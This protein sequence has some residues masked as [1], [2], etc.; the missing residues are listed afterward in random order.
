MK[1][2]SEKAKEFLEHFADEV[3]QEVQRKLGRIALLIKQDFSD[4]VSGNKEAYSD[5]R[6]EPVFGKS[7]SGYIPFQNGGFTVSKFFLNDED[8][9]YHFTE[10]QTEYNQEQAK[11]CYEA[12]LMDNGLDR[13]TEYDSLT[14]EQQESL[15][16]YE[17]DWF[18]PAL[19]SF[20][21]FADGFKEGFYD[22]KKP[23]VLFR[24]SINY[25]DAPYYRERDEEDIISFTLDIEEFLAMP[26]QEIIDK[27]KV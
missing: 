17:R 12:F 24:T 22:S 14:E 27:L 5:E 13:E 16:E 15:F 8:S 4:M 25:K 7:Y 9:T 26:E 3:P 6:L 10:K 20:T 1:K 11:N 19:L 23:Y 21:M 18:E 2:L